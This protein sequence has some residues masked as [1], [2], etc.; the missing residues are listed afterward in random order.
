MEVVV[1]SEVSVQDPNSGIQL[2]TGSIDTQRLLQDDAADG[3]NFWFVRN[4]FANDSG[5]SFKTPRHHHPFAQIKMVEKGSSNVY[6]GKDIEEGDIAYFPR[7][8]Y[9]GPQDKDNCT[10]FGMQFGFNGQHQRGERWEDRRAEAMERLQARGH[11]EGGVFIEKD[12]VTGQT[13]TRD[14]IEAL[15]DE[16]LQLVS[17]KRLVVE[18]EGYD[19]VIMMHPRSFPYFPVSPGVDLKHL[20]RFFDQPGPNGDVAISVVRLSDD[21]RYPLGEDRAQLGWTMRDGLR[22]DGRSYPALTSFYSP[23]GEVSEIAGSDGVE[24]YLVVFPRLD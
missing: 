4:T 20:G 24:V 7:A 16:R 12:P 2:R 15:Y 18:P 14:S 10:S 1:A 5:E 3:L 19:S 6:P 11:V 23:R 13:H 8:A 9:Y 22:I 21:G 17:G